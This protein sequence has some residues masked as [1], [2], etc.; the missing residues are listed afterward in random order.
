MWTDL[1]RPYQ[2]CTKY[3]RAITTC[4]ATTLRTYVCALLHFSEQACAANSWNVHV[5]HHMSNWLYM[6]ICVILPAYV[7]LRRLPPCHVLLDA[8]LRTCVWTCMHV[9]ALTVHAVC[10]TRNVNACSYAQVKRGNMHAYLRRVQGLRTNG[11]HAYKRAYDMH[12]F[13]T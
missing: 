12:T 6:R 7:Q 5:V 3:V 13:G 1:A 11:P 8:V 4:V 10:V 2:Q 9:R